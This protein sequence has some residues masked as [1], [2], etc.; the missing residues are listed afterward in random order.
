MPTMSSYVKWVSYNLSCI[1]MGLGS[2]SDL[3]ILALKLL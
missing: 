3:I 1:L 2:L